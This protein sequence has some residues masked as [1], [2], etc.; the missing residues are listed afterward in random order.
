MLKRYVSRLTST[1][2]F[3]ANIRLMAGITLFIWCFMLMYGLLVYKPMY[4]AESVVMIKDSAIVSLISVQ[5]LTFLATEVA[6]TT[7][8]NAERLF[9]LNTH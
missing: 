4:T 6:S 7:T 2:F 9:S 5:E 8:A 1:R 3:R